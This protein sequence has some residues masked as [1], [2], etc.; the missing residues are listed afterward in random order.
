MLGT[1]TD[2]TEIELGPRPQE[3]EEIDGEAT[4]RC[5]NRATLRQDH[6]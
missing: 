2:R 5:G 1:Q 6:D 4:V 3:R